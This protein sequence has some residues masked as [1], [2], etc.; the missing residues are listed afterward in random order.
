MA[1]RR[2]CDTAQV[3]DWNDYRYFLALAREGTLAGAARALTVDHTTVSRRVAAL[4]AALG[5]KL[6]VRTP[7]GFALTQAGQD[8][9][10]LVARAADA[11]EAVALR[12]GGEDG[13]LRGTVRV[14]VSEAFAPFIVKRLVD[15]R[16]RH[17]EIVIEVLTTN[18]VSDLTRREAD[19]AVRFVPTPQGE[20]LSRKIGNV[21]WV[22]CASESYLGRA[23]T[24]VDFNL[25]GHDVIAYD[26]ERASL[27]GAQWINSHAAGARIV[28]RSSS[29]ISA[30]NAAT[31]GM[32]LAVVPAHLL[33]GEPTLRAIGPSFMQSDIFIVVH[34]D[35]AKI[36]RIRA[37]MD[38]I[39]DIVR[40]DAALL[41]GTSQR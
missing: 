16:Q 22:A 39:A 19:I 8:A 12:V 23:G 14:T 28:M 15:M 9:Q 20:L 3:A 24:P 33:S 32:G 17:P 1:A 13:E 6:F 7:D 26:D 10:P 11:L 34:P 40:R 29:I 31:M 18:V 2:P 27:A 21:A 4:E 25:A 41:N 38:F 37:V 5:T 36:A 30:L 35:L